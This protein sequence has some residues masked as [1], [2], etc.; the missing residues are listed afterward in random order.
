MAPSRRVVARKAGAPQRGA[1]IG[2]TQ[3]KGPVNGDA[4][5]EVRMNRVDLV[6]QCR[7][8]GSHP[9]IMRLEPAPASTRRSV[10]RLGNRVT[11]AFTG[12]LALDIS[13]DNA[14]RGY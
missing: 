6:R 13:G 7:V 10:A 1:G 14:S 11:I 5:V 2:A 9:S 4:T 3:S 12:R 8:M